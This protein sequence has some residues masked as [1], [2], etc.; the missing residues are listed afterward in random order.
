MWRKEG[1]NGSDQSGCSVGVG[2][3]EAAVAAVEVVTV[4]VVGAAVEG[5]PPGRST[6]SFG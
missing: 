3:A 4:L 6:V 2:S 1:W 5:E